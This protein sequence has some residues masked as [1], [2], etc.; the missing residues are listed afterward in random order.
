MDRCRLVK[1][2]ISY[3]KEILSFRKEMLDVGSSMDGSGPLRRMESVAEWL[4]FNRRAENSDTVPAGLV[5]ADQYVYVREADGRI[6]GMIQ[7]AAAST[8]FS[9]STVAISAIPSGREREGRGTRRG[10]FPTACRSAGRTG[11]GRS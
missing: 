1:P 8:I 7:P 10:C 5:A 4:E 3:E 2:D 11:S 6:V 9:R